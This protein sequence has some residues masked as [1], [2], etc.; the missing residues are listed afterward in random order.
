MTARA[1]SK[2]TR[3]CSRLPGLRRGPR[4]RV[5]V[6]G[7][8]GMLGSD[9]APPDRRRLRCARPAEGGARRRRRGRALALAERAATRGRRQLCRLHE[10]RRLRDGSPGVRGQRRGC[11]EPR[12]CLRPC[13]CAARPD[14]DRLRLRR[15]EGEPLPRG[16]SGGSAVRVRTVQARRRRRGDAA[17]GQPRRPR[18]LAV[19]PLRLELHRGDPRSRSSRARRVSPSSSI[20]S[21]G[22]PR[23]PTSP[24]R[25]WP[26]STRAPPASITSPT[27]A[28]SPG[29][30]SRGDPLARRTHGSVAVDP[31]TAEALARPASRPAVLRSRHRQVR[32]ADRAPH[33][34]LSRSARRVPGAPRAARS[35]TRGSRRGRR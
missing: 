1:P 10:G 26:C 14:L 28:R 29:T 6:T 25:C 33:S 31:T 23:R 12:G 2:P 32:A 34:A 21:A 15:R 8:S 27:A 30:T 19:R 3:P 7:A 9:L 22:R 16:R 18:L 24:R 11:R 5:L 4:R 35:V 20:R 13:R 17:A